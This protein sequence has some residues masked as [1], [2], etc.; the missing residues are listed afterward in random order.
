M[1]TEARPREAVHPVRVGIR[2]LVSA[3]E[4]ASLRVERVLSG[5]EGT[6][7]LIAFAPTKGELR[8][9]LESLFEEL[10]VVLTTK[11]TEGDRADRP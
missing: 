8:E 1:D 6:F 7:E 5:E 9:V 4:G 3:P 2:L 10:F 11:D